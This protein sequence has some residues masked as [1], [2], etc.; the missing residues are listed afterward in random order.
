MK[1]WSNIAV[2]LAGIFALGSCNF[3]GLNE[4]VLEKKNVGVNI[5]L[6]WSATDAAQPEDMYIA[7]SRILN[8]VHYAYL[9]PQMT[10]LVPGAE[11]VPTWLGGEYNVLCFSKRDD[12][13]LGGLDEFAASADGSM[14]RVSLSIPKLTEEQKT[15]VIGEG[16]KDYNS[17]VE[18]VADAGRMY[19]DIKTVT[20]SPENP[21]VVLAPRQLNQD[22]TIRFSMH[23]DEEVTIEN[24]NAVMSGVVGTVFPMAGVVNFTDLYRVPMPVKEVGVEGK[25]RHY[26]AKASVLGLFASKYADSTTGPGIFQLVVSATSFLGSRTY[27]AGINLMNTINEAGIMDVTEG[28]LGY[29]AASDKVV[30]EIPAALHITTLRIEEEG[31]K[32][33]VDAWFNNENI[34]VDL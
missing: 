23:V 17:K 27:Y 24:I 18:F 20:V 8:T 4:E 26:E 3:A 11:A 33:G 25:I 9:Y 22:L 1:N 16:K 15:A 7:A 28:E 30:L 2:L 13:I 6:D 14:K 10:S 32:D 29:V 21:D 5:S 34:D 12:L 31:S 19:A